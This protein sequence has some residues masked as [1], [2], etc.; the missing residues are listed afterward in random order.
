MTFNLKSVCLCAAVCTI[1]ALPQVGFG[2]TSSSNVAY[3]YLSA[4]ESSSSRDHVVAFAANRDGA[5]S[6]VPGS[7]FAANVAQMAVNG[8]YLFG[9]DRNQIDI[10]AW[11]IDSDG[12]LDFSNT[13]SV[14]QANGNCDVPGP[15]VLDHTGAS[16][17]NND[18]NCTNNAYQALAVEDAAGTLRFLNYASSGSPEY[19]GPLSF[20]GNNEY[21]YSASC[22]NFIPAIFGVKR[23]S[24][25]AITMLK[26]YPPLPKAKSGSWC[27]YLAAADPA[28]HLAVPMYPSNDGPQEGP[29]Q[30]AVYTANSAGDLSTSSTYANM[31]EV[32]VGVVTDIKMAPGGKLV[33]VAGRS[34][35]QV[36]HFN[37]A[38]PITAYTGLLTKDEIDQV[39]WDN[40]NHLY[41]ISRSAGK[42][43][44]FTV[45][46]TRYSQ[47]SGSPH[48]VTAPVN[49][50][51]QPL[52]LP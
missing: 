33:A 12:S 37:G 43:F 52:P 9:S 8:K 24:D 7:P 41:G 36:F 5:L 29:Y 44:V 18:I 45:T 11:R 31:P 4:Y 47:A 34:G 10:D 46:T 51:V 27:P 2:Q 23:S 40:D 35:L 48:A 28:N 30:L 42:L 1:A 39:F 21:A 20:I 22:Y 49:L 14:Q 38:S 16:L 6:A 50:I 15:I 26:S 3:V 13:T 32:A 19:E 25:G 17:Y